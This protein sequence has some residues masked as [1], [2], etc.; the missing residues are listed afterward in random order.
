MPSC[1]YS[2]CLDNSDLQSVR[3]GG[4]NHVLRAGASAVPEAHEMRPVPA[5]LLVPDRPRRLAVPVPIGWA[6]DNAVAVLS[7]IALTQLVRATCA[8]RDDLERFREIREDA[9]QLE[10]HELEVIE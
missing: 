8:T 5:H 3:C 2:L 9:V 1:W 6:P 4:L 10:F 7:G